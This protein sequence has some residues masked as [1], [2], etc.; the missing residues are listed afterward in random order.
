MVGE[1]HDLQKWT[2]NSSSVAV[3]A[4]IDRGKTSQRSL[5]VLGVQPQCWR[6]ARG[7]AASKQ[8]MPFAYCQNRCGLSE[9]LSCRCLQWERLAEGR[10]FFTLALLHLATCAGD[11]HCRYSHVGVKISHL[12]DSSFVSALPGASPGQETQH[13][14]GY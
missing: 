7:N 10:V 3:L 13:T 14:D 1:K 8:R 4:L 12:L 6:K 2:R 11:A 5:L 9:C